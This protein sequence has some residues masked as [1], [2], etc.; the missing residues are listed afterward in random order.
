MIREGQL[1]TGRKK[2]SEETGIPETT[3]ERILNVFE[4]EQQIGQ[5][6]TTKYRLITILNWKEHQ[7]VDSKRTANGQRTDTNKNVRREE[8]TSE[9]EL[10]VVSGEENTPIKKSPK[11]PHAKDVFSW[12]PSP[13]PSWSINTTELKHAELLWER[14]E[15]KVKGAL[16]FVAKHR[17]EDFFPKITKPSDLERKW[18]DISEYEA[19]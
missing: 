2:L 7:E 6:K 1:I 9:A 5:Q 13:E 14:G 17:E 16:A 4:N 15:K 3:I 10:R 18:V 12:F 19:N 11:Y 8:D